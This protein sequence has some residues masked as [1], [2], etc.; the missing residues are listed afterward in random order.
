MLK[1]SLIPLALLASAAS[2]WDFVVY[3][4]SEGELT[5]T[6]EFSE[7][8]N[9]ICRNTPENAGSF[10]ISN[11]GNCILYLYSDLDTC[12]D[13]GDVQN[14]EDLYDFGDEDQTIAPDFTWDNW[15]VGD[16]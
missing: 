10:E 4:D 5:P 1:I 15:Y 3:P 13:D 7:D 8:G 11:M 9:T 16:C 6:A 14:W 2:C 12:R